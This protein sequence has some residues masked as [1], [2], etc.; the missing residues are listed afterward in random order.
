VVTPRFGHYD[1]AGGREMWLRFGPDD[2]PAVVLVLPL[3]EEANRARAM[4]LAILRALAAHGVGGVLPDLPGTGE[5]TAPTEGLTLLRLRK[6][7][8]EAVA[9]L[10]R[11]GRRTYLVTMRGGAL[12]DDSTLAFGRWQ[13]SPLMGAEMLR[14]LGRVLQTAARDRRGDPLAGAVD[15]PPVIV[16]GNPVSRALLA[17]LRDA[18]PMTAAEGVRLRIARYLSD[19][20]PADVKLPGTAPWR[21]AEPGHDADTVTACADDIAA[22]VR[23]CEA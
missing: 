19:A 17:E 9:A 2:G 5:S 22:W 1:W 13:L 7:L 12:L 21:R 14:D 4:G 8:R 20:R 18:T 6:A 16:A 3:F 11:E 15:G 10:D 23:A